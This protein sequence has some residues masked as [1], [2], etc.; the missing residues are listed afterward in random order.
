M[1]WV[2]REERRELEGGV[3]PVAGVF[4]GGAEVGAALV[5]AGVVA[6]F[7]GAG[8]GASAIKT[9]VVSVLTG[10]E[11]AGSSL[12]GSGMGASGVE[13]R[14]SIAATMRT[15][16]SLMQLTLPS[17]TRIMSLLFREEPNWRA[18]CGG[19]LNCDELNLLNA[20]TRVKDASSARNIM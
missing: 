19:A 1:G 8:A 10:S 5:G 13:S 12:V 7:T 9:S 11:G 15:C 17:V 6:S 18:T 4:A 14:S 16:F 3:G 2:R 20:M